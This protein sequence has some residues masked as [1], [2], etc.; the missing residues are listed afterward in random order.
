M[1]VRRDDERRVPIP[2]ERRAVLVFLRLNADALAGTLV[3]AC[4]HAVLERGV[5]RVRILGVDARHEAV[6]VLGHEPVLVQDA[7]LGTGPRRSA[8]RIVVLQSAVDVIERRRVVGVDVVVL[9]ERQV[10]EEGPGRG[11][12]KR[13]VEAAVVADQQVAG[14]VRIDPDDVVVDVHVPLAKRPQRLTAIVG[15]LEDHVG[16]VDAIDVNR[17][18]EDVA[19]I[20]CTGVVVSA[21]LPGDAVVG[22]AIDAALAIGRLDVGVK[23][24]GVHRRD[25]QADAPELLVG[26]SGGDLFPGLAAIGAA[27][28]RAVGT[29]VDQRVETALP[30]VGRRDQHVGVA[31]IEHDIGDAG[32]L[33]NLQHL[34][35]RLAAV[36]RLVQPAL[37]AGRPQRP[38]RGDVDGVAV[39]RVDDDPADVLG[40]LQPG[41]GPRTAAVFALVDAVAVGDRALRIAL[42]SA[43]P[44]DVRPLWIERH[45][46]DRERSLC[47]EDRLPRGAA[48]DGLPHAAGGGPDVD[49]CLVRRIDSDRHHAA[50]R[51]RGADRARFQTGERVGRT[52]LRGRMR[53][54]HQREQTCGSNEDTAQHATNCNSARVE[55]RIARGSTRWRGRCQFTSADCA[56]VTDFSASV[57]GLCV[58]GGSTRRV[59]PSRVRTAARL[60]RG[61]CRECFATRLDA[62]SRSSR[63]QDRHARLSPA[64]P[65]RSPRT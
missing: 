56:D 43:D 4:H 5:D 13:A 53:N 55:R 24:V 41:I 48:V 29:A 19:V 1:R 46:A 36:G 35:P 65:R 10:R 45:P 18:G 32:V 27:M 63:R 39:P 20:H 17:V 9:R 7:V 64:S 44:D 14:V 22:R 37:A 16:N 26:Q 31:R 52:R 51:D 61:T 3:D 2:A 34:R 11:A 60:Y 42:A 23:D 49:D 59:G 6:A 62:G 28:D 25:S 40:G 58:R 12:I 21:P 54:R 30:L 47:V 38:L 8:E 15:D 57:C 50:R 33:G